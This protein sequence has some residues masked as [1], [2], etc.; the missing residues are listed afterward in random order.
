MIAAIF[1]MVGDVKHRVRAYMRPDSAVEQQIQRCLL[2]G[3]DPEPMLKSGYGLFDSVERSPSLFDDEMFP[4]T[5]EIADRV[6][7]VWAYDRFVCGK[8]RAF[9]ISLEEARYKNATLAKIG[10]G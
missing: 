7:A 5:A 2:M 8:D 4:V 9:W 3:I 1:Q 6:R 10:G